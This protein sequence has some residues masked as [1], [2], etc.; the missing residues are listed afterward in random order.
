MHSSSANHVEKFGKTK[1]AGREKL[2]GQRDNKK[3]NKT[4]RGRREEVEYE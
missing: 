1:K 2:S 4:V 3:R